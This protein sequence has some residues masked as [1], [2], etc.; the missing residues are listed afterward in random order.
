MSLELE[1]VKSNVVLPIE[2][3]ISQN[4]RHCVGLK[5]YSNFSSVH[6]NSSCGCQ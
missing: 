4:T 3:S 2:R 6:Q 1:Y 5:H